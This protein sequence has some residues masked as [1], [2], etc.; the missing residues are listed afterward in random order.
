MVVRLLIVMLALGGL[1]FR[2]CSCA[3]ERT[4]LAT[5][6]SDGVESDPAHH[7]HD[8]DCPMAKPVHPKPA[9]TEARIAVVPDLA[10]DLLAPPLMPVDVSGRRDPD[11]DAGPLASSGPIW[12]AHLAIQI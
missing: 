10:I 12:L 2:V 5:V 9:L 4:A 8:P 6:A 7:E 1:P 11:R 3:H